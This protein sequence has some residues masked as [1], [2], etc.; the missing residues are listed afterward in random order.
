VI[1]DFDS[2]AK[3]LESAAKAA[4]AKEAH[5][6]AKEMRDG[7]R[8]QR[9]AREARPPW[10]PLAESTVARKGS[11]KMLIDTGTLMRAIVAE[12]V[13]NMKWLVGVKRGARTRDGQKLVNI[14]AVHEFGSSGRSK[15]GGVAVRIPKRQFIA[16]VLRRMSRGVEKRLWERF[17]K[18]IEK[19]LSHRKLV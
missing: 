2:F 3:K 16:P 12:R 15:G 8:T 19:H 6:W 14:A 10:P 9:S 11:T 5:E 17:Q 13:S 7:I 18:E 4:I 1:K